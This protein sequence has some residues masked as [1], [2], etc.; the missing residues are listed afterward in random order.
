MLVVS[1]WT[2]LNWETGRTEPLAASVPALSR[3]F[4]LRPLR[5]PQTSPLSGFYP[6]ARPSPGQ[7]EP[8]GITPARPDAFSLPHDNRNCRQVRIQESDDRAHHRPDGV[9]RNLGTR[10]KVSF[11]SGVHCTADKYGGGH[12]PGD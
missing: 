3:W 7:S 9:D 6:R 12:F 4:G 10:T 11:Q 5:G 1:P 8:S 2:V